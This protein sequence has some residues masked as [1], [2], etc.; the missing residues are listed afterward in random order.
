MSDDPVTIESELVESGFM[1]PRKVKITYKCPS[2]EHIYVRTFKAAPPPGKDPPC[3][4]PRCIAD[5]ETSELKRQVENLTR[6][7]ME[8]R[9]PVQI[10]HK[11]IVKAIDTTA[12][13]VM[14]DNKLT[15]LKDSIREGESMAPKLPPQMQ[16]AAD[17]FF[18]G[19]KGVLGGPKNMRAAKF[20]AQ[21]DSVGRRALR[22]DFRLGALPPNVV[23]SPAR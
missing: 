20:Q 9:A 6:M 16:M 22:G 10:G 7:L 8:Q 4:R 13:I 19:P 14:Q 3:P 2:C 18:G 11:P 5:R 15:D 17:G 21:M 23:A 12:D 1:Q